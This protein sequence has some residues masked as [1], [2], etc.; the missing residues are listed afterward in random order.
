[1]GEEE[2]ISKIT[3]WEVLSQKVWAEAVTHFYAEIEGPQNQ[4]CTFEFE[5]KKITLACFLALL[6]L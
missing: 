2:N 1:M 6:R 5:L 3:F 4:I